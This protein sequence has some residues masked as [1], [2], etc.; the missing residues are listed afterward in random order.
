MTVSSLARTLN[1][2]VQDS[3]RILN[4]YLEDNRKL[5][6]DCLAAT[7]VLVGTRKNE[8]CVV[9]LVK[10]I[11]VK[12]KRDDFKEITSETLYSLQKSKDVDLNIV[13]LADWSNSKNSTEEPKPL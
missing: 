8:K 2:P 12:S 6:P 3:V 10:E 4:K 7:Y 1:I 9:C 13:D 11:D 5:K